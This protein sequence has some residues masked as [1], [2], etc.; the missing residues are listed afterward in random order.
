[1]VITKLDRFGRNARDSLNALHLLE[2]SRC[3][4]VSITEDFGDGGM[5]KVLRNMVASL[6]EYDVTAYALAFESLLLVGGKLGDRF[7]RKWTFIAGLL[8]SPS[9]L[10]L[11]GWPSRSACWWPRGHCRAPSERSWP[12]PRCRR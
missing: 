2:Q 5:G 6:A 12:P 10:S 9:P 4:V 11:A 8:G 1:M 3:A 7:G